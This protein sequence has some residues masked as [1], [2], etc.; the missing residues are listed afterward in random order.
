M[1]PVKV[2]RDPAPSRMKYRLER[3]WLR[4][5]IRNF[6][7]R[8]LPLAVLAGA[9]ISLLADPQFRQGVATQADALRD[10]VA[11]HPGLMVTTLSLP[12]ASAE[13]ADRVRGA[14]G[15][16]LPVSSMDLDLS[17]L[18][19]RIEALPPVADAH[20]R[21][22]PGGVL[23]IT[24]TERVPVLVWRTEDGLRLIDV[25]GV[26]VDTVAARAARPDLPLVAGAGADRAVP[27][28][29]RLFRLADDVAGRVRALVRVGERRWDLVLDRDQVIRLPAVGAEAALARVMALQAAEQ[30]LDRD[31]TVVD[32]RDGR[33]PILRLSPAAQV[34]F[35][36]RRAGADGD[37]T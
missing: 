14:L 10:R 20:V 18:H 24:V 6:V 34:E 28:A 15:V 31:I 17:V 35:L 30:V 22:E 11:A 27:E 7:R 23:E 4:P 1:L 32:L 21:L 5:T 36:R 25:A 8:G 12:G 19:D 3:L 16:D 37:R 2:P 26:T 29:V 9:A 13:M 33:R